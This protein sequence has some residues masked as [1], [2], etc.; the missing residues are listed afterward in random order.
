MCLIKELVNVEFGNHVIICNILLE[1]FAQN[2][3]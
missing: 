1:V 3:L 2:V